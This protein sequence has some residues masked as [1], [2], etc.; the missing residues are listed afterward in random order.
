MYKINNEFISYVYL[1]TCYVV[2]EFGIRAQ[3]RLKTYCC[4][5]CCFV[6]FIIEDFINKQFSFIIECDL[7]G[8]GS[9]HAQTSGVFTGQRSGRI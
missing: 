2:G 7:M 3:P 4:N 1:T 6:N 9:Q 5:T 8:V